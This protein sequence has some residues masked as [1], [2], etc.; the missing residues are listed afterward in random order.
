[1]GEGKDKLQRDLSSFAAVAKSWN[2]NFKSECVIIRFVEQKLVREEVYFIEGK[3]F[4]F[5]GTHKDLGIVIDLGLR[6]H[7]HVN[8]LVRGI[9]GDL[10][11]LFVSHIHPIIDYWSMNH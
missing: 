8:S 1:M 7:V 6:F 4:V 5:V 3:R 2:L 10:L 11:S 9:M